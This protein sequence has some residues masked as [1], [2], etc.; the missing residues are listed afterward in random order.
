METNLKNI[1]DLINNQS[2]LENEKN[3]KIAS[4]SLVCAIVDIA[5]I[6]GE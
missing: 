5:Q 2:D 1:S 6:V 3:F 4:A